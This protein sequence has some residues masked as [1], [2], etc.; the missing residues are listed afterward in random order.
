MGQVRHGSATTTH[1]VRV[2]MQRL[3]A[4]LAQLSRGWCNQSELVPVYSS[5]RV[6]LPRTKLTPLRECS[7]SVEFEIVMRV[8]CEFLVKMI[9]K[10]EWTDANFC[11]HRICL[12]RSMARSRRRNGRM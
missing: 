2:A 5:A 12:K 7:G 4:S 9:V 11:R 10:E 6:N 1:A 8:E 3:Q